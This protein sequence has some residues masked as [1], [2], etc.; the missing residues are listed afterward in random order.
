MKALVIEDDLKIVELISLA[1]QAG[2]PG[3]TLITAHRGEEGIDLAENQAPDLIILDPELP[4]VDGFDLLKQIRLF[5]RIPVVIVTDRTDEMS[6]VKGLEWGADE[7]ISKKFGQMELMARIRAILRR[8]YPPGEELPLAYG[9]LC[10]YT[11]TGKLTCCRKDIELTR[12]ESQILQH[13]IRNAGRVVSHS[14]L[15]TTLWGEDYPDSVDALR[16]YIRRL[17]VKIETDPNIPQLILTK[18]GI[19]YFLAEQVKP[20][21][22]A[23]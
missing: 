13:L 2:W 14:G 15:A 1:F 17:R 9:P 7:Y 8:H 5:C 10:L 12:T 4:D 19:G 18:P 20:I 6:I 23:T 3:A 11:S 21:P 22:V 16:V